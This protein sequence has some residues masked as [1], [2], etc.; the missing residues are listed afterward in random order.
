MKKVLITGKDSYIGISL[1]QW[2]MKEP[3][4]Y[5][6]DTV[7][8]KDESWKEKDFSEYD[9]VFHVAGIAHVKETQEN[10]DLY[11]K[12]NTDLAVEAAKKAKKEGVEQFIFLSSMSVY[13][14]EKGI[15]TES[16]ALLPKTAYGKSKMEAEALIRDLQTDSFVIA[17]L[18]PPMVYGK[19]CK[20]NYPRL[21]EFAL[22]IPVF[23][24]IDNE[25]SMIYID[26]LTE[27]VKNLID[28]RKD[29]LFFPQNAEYV[30]TSEMVRLIAEIHGKKMIMTKLFNP[31]LRMMNISTINKLFGNLVYD[32]NIAS[33]ISLVEFVET[34]RK[35]E[36]K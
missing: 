25:R 18:R 28:Q 24:N 27:F 1:E 29:G 15:I 30:N 9:T 35:T 4:N 26:N 23:P 14:V 19:G 31:I 12:I 21:A 2:L 6:V 8:M 33:N 13:G 36:N 5:Q 7:D 10:R 11:Q 3:D 16:T 32:K 34:I 22:K 17:V 20:G